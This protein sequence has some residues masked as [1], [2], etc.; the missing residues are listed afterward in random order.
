MR[1]T[2]AHPQAIDAALAASARWLHDHDGAAR[3][4]GARGLALT[5]ARTFA[6]ALLVRARDGADEAAGAALAL[7]LDHGLDRLAGAGAAHASALLR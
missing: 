7:F 4:A 5:L 6:A 1:E 2:R 3:E